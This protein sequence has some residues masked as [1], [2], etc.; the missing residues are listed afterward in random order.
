MDTQLAGLDRFE[1]ALAAVR[2]LG[3]AGALALFVSSVEP[4]G[5][6][7]SWS[8]VGVPPI[9]AGGAVGAFFVFLALAARRAPRPALRHRDRAV[10]I[11]CGLLAGIAVPVLVG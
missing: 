3:F 6:G 7:S 5:L 4:F 1:V 8:P 9:F 11:A 2:G 10:C